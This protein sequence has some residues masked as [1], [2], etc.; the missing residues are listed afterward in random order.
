MNCV[1][2]QLPWQC[3]SNV[4]HIAMQRQANHTE[5]SPVFS[6]VLHTR[7]WLPSLRGVVTERKR[8]MGSGSPSNLLCHNSTSRQAI[9]IQV[10]V[11]Y[12]RSLVACLPGSVPLVDWWERR[13]VVISWCFYFDSSLTPPF[14]WSDHWPICIELQLSNCQTLYVQRQ[15][16]AGHSTRW[17]LGH[18]TSPRSV[19]HDCFYH[20]LHPL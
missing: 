9:L 17:H 2:R 8:N 1:N 3:A 10:S 6:A 12:N 5:P 18:C 20:L 4:C 15:E 19:P 11:Q 7:A 13:F 16:H 14:V